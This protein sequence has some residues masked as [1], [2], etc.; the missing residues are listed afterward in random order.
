MHP[1]ERMLGHH[2][3][4]H[5]DCYYDNIGGDDHRLSV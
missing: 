3:L 1:H 2:L 5:D 4:C